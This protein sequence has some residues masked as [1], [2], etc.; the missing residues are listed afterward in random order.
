MASIAGYA[1][2]T[3]SFTGAF[4][5]QIATVTLSAASPTPTDDVVLAMTATCRLTVAVPSPPVV[6]PPQ[7]VRKAVSVAYDTPVI[8]QGKPYLP[9]FSGLI[10]PGGSAN[11]GYGHIRQIVDP[12]PVW[13]GSAWT[14]EPPAY[15]PG[16]NFIR[17]TA[18]TLP[19]PAGY[20]GGAY[21][22]GTADAADGTAGMTL[23]GTRW[24]SAPGSSVT[25]PWQSAYPFKPT[26]SNLVHYNAD[27]SQHVQDVGIHFNA[28]QVDHMWADMGSFLTPPFTVILVALVSR[29]LSGQY[30]NYLL[31]SGRDPT[32]QLT[33]A[34]RKAWLAA[35]GLPGP[36]ALTAENLGYRTALAVARPGTL[37]YN[38]QP[39][40]GRYGR[41]R[42]ANNYRPK[43]FAEVFNGGASATGNWSASGVNY[44]AASLANHGSQRLAV[45][46]RANGGLN[47]IYAA[48]MVLF[49][50]RVWDKALSKD[51]LQA[52]Y[53]QLSST[54]RFHAYK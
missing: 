7:R 11:R 39:Y 44:A 45:L 33:V 50:M 36:V 6:S 49:E 42:Y 31:D 43:M 53:D 16:A 46:G 34:Q 51:Q 47:P 29:F 54:W 21:Q 20:S 2:F 28:S 10:T 37:M 48:S 38:D 12:D 27:G 8:F 19:S 4:G 13:D 5:G 18:K 35:G 24:Q 26:V 41:V 25:I 30:A 17:W 32:G 3:G 23:E 9:K 52:Q 15:P 40:V 1:G 22:L 14:V